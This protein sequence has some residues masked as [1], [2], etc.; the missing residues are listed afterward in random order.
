MNRQT[1]HA[2]GRLVNKRSAGVVLGKL[3][4]A[5]A[6]AIVATL[7]VGMM[8]GIPRDVE[9][10]ERKLQ[11]F[12]QASYKDGRAVSDEVRNKT[13]TEQG[14]TFHVPSSS[15]APSVGQY[16]V[17]NLFEGALR[18]YPGVFGIALLL[19]LSV[20]RPGMYAG[21][22]VTVVIAPLALILGQKLA[23]CV[24]LVGLVYFA[25]EKVRT[26]ARAALG[27]GT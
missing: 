24:A 19:F 8:F 13:L 6:L 16:K 3:L 25:L 21:V 12:E 27:A 23:I 17:M 10:L 1:D 9:S 20:I 5:V 2:G 26:R 22:S 14:H 11:A 18:W 15:S 4:M 7:V